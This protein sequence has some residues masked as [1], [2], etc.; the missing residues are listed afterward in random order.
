MNIESGSSKERQIVVGLLVAKAGFPLAL[1]SFK[2][3]KAE[4]KMIEP[5]LKEFKE[6]NEM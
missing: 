5:V 2:S 6:E 1:H 4:A 3:N